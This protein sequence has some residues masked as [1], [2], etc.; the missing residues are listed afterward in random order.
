MALSIKDEETD[1]LVRRLARAKR[2]SFTGAIRLAVSNE[3]R[4][5]GID[6]GI[7]RNEEFIKAVREAQAMFRAMPVDPELAALTED[8]I[9]GYDEN[10]IPTQPK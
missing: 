1:R 3:L 9:L 7:K 4:R 10:G 2:T 8:E 6:D 5:S